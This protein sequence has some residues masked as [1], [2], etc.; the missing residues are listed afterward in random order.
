M[1]VSQ[2][3][4][5]PCRRSVCIKMA[6]ELGHFT[7]IRYKLNSILSC[8][9]DTVTKIVVKEA[10]H[11]Q[12][13]YAVTICPTVLLLPKISVVA[14][15]MAVCKKI[16]YE[17]GCL[18]CIRYKLYS[19]LCCLNITYELGHLICIRYKQYSTLSCGSDT[20]MYIKVKNAFHK[21]VSYTVTIIS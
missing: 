3:S 9:S 21:Q 20:A 15:R 17:L 4:I 14:H 7:Y 16:T 11:K 10:I 13:N 6:H 8:M 2:V 5:V 19:I 12:A 1:L 18:T